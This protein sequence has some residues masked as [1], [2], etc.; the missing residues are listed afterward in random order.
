MP[1]YTKLAEQY[2]KI[3]DSLKI[4]KTKIINPRYFAALHS[5]YTLIPE[6]YFT[7]FFCTNIRELRQIFNIFRAFNILYSLELLLNTAS[8]QFIEEYKIKARKKLCSYSE[9]KKNR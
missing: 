3:E 5:T 9:T 4:V 1:K 7:D 8:N 2:S 6:T